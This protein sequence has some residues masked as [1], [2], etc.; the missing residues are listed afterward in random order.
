VELSVMPWQRVNTD[1]KKKSMILIMKSVIAYS[2]GFLEVFIKQGV[3]DLK[4]W[5]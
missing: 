2:A 5:K 4:I 1:K 3:S